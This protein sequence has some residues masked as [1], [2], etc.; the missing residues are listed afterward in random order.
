MKTFDELYRD[1][2]AQKVSLKAPLPPEY[3]PYHLDCLLHPERNAPVLFDEPCTDCAYER[4]CQNSCIFDAIEEGS[5]GKLFINP[6]LCTGCGVCIDACENHNISAGKDI[7]PAMKAVREAK[8]PAY[9]MVAPAFLG[10]FTENV[11]P[12][13]LR[14][15]FRA[16][17]FSGMVEVALF[18]DIL[19]LKEAL[20]FDKH[21][22]EK[23]D[24]QLTS[25]CCPVWIAMIRKM[26][27]ELMPHVPGAVS[28]MVACGR[29]IKLLHPDAVT[30]F[31][32]PCLA[33]KSEAR[34]KDVAGAVDYVLTF[35]EVQ[36]IFE[37][38]DIHP[39][40]L[41]DQEK[42]HSSRAG[43]IYARTGGVS[44]AVRET[45]RQLRP[46]RKIKVRAEQADGIQDCRALISRIQNQE[47]D[48]NFF[49][50]MGC[51]GGC[52]GG[53]KAIL[54]KDEG[55]R[56]VDEYGDQALFATPLENP[57]VMKMLEKLGF[58]TVEDFIENSELLVRDFS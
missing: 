26:Y 34:E 27:K 25:C 13:K 1:I 38:A 57:Y 42:E 31:A 50:G 28:P 55:K 40:E 32:G 58:T 39:E 2:L 37:A 5:D 3:E 8:G 51:P 21:I 23:G 49:E 56:F 47:T 30:V 9:M 22:L 41:E 16:L 11:T 46:D 15:A 53:P 52:V 29:M 12:G 43:R 54:N 20:E 45:E 35:Q 44:E 33:K 24:Y 48:A 19:T 14:T 36:D 18:A 10:Q 7:L 6:N 17:G 4:A